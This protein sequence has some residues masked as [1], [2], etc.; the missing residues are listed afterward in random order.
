MSIRDKI[1]EKT[2]DGPNYFKS[3]YSGVE[4]NIEPRYKYACLEGK[5]ADLLENKFG[6]YNPC[7]IDDELTDLVNLLKLFKDKNFNEKFETKEMRLLYFILEITDLIEGRTYLSNLSELTEL[8]EEM[9]NLD[10]L[11]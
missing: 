10:P 4:I 5:M 9:L 8:G 1:Y 6:Y 7:I 3:Y 11:K 2:N